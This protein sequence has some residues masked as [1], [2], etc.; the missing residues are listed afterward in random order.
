MEDHFF[1]FK[2]KTTSIYQL[3]P[4]L[5]ILKMEGH[6]NISQKE[7]NLN[8]LG[9][10]RQP[11]HFVSLKADIDSRIY[12]KPIMIWFRFLIKPIPKWV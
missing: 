10:E 8:I 3:E 4:N 2:W 1:F 7:D 9:S 12:I 11:Q 6:L 5:N